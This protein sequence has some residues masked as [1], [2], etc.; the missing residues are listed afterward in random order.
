[1]SATPKEQGQDVTHELMASPTITITQPGYI[2]IYLSN[3][4]TSPVEVYFDDFR[5]TNTKSA[6]VQVDDY[7][8]FGLAFNSYNRENTT[9]NQYKFSGKEEQDELDLGWMDYGARMYQPEITRWNKIDPLSDAYY[10]H[11]P[12][13]FVLG[14]PVSN[15]DVKGMWTVSRHNKMTLQALSTVGI[16]GE[17]AQ[18]IADYCTHPINQTS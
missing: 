17:Q 15:I 4:E 8:P 12:Y 9:P 13:S 11:S 16:G 2:Y 6:V 14:N 3:E 7:Y 10:S 5:V 18:L 1:M